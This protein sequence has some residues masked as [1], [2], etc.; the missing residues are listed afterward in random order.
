[1]HIQR[2]IAYIRM[3][4][5]FDGWNWNWKQFMRLGVSILSTHFQVLLIRSFFRV[6]FLPPVYCSITF[7][8]LIL[9]C[10]RVV[11]S[12]SKCMSGCGCGDAV[13]ILV[14]E[15]K[16]QKLLT[17][18]SLKSPIRL[19]LLTVLTKYIIFHKYRYRKFIGICWV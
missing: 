4:H 8:F 3:M 17:L 15:V 7:S 2:Q 11:P 14:R 9:F 5:Y 1:M 12:L 19:F 6:S 18:L 16:E 10:M 13:V